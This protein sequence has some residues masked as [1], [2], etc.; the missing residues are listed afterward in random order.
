MLRIE[1]GKISLLT[2]SASIKALISATD[3]E[4]SISSVDTNNSIGS[5]LEE[6]TESDRSACDN[7][8]GDFSVGWLFFLFGLC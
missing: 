8:A 7:L 3:N 2:K 5:D 4:F 1:W 6:D